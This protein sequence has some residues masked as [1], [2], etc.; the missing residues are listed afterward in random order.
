MDC[1]P[2]PRDYNEVFSRSFSRSSSRRY[3]RRGLSRLAGRMVDFIESRGI[4]GATVL[5]I[6]GGIGDLHVELLRRGARSATNLELSTSYDDDARA[7]LARYGLSDRVERRVLDIAR[8]PEAVEAAGIV[9][10]NRVVCCYPDYVGLLAAAGER[11]DALLVFSY[12]S[13]SVANRLL[14]RLENAWHRV[15][16]RDFRAYAHD[17]TAMVKVVEGTGLRQVMEH[18]G[19]VWSVAGFERT[20][21]LAR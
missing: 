7:L 13:R 4:G 10:L 18:R 8:D 2:E 19:L 11:A 3:E 14:L 17:P 15:R 16:G 12:P 9:V 1:C 5:E 21:A 6:G 20:S